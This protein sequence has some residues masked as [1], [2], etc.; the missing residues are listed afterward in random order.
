MGL[1]LASSFVEQ[2]VGT[3]WTVKPGSTI[4]SQSSGFSTWTHQ[5]QLGYYL[6]GLIEGDGSILV[7]EK[8]Q[9]GKVRYPYFK[10]TFHLNNL[11]WANKI[12]EVLGFGT[13]C[14]PKGKNYAVLT[15]YSKEGVLA[16]TNLING[17]MRTPKIEALHRLINMVNQH[18]PNPIPL[19]PLDTTPIGSNAWLAG[20]T[21]SDGNFEVVSMT[22]IRKEITGFKCR[23]KIEQRLEYH[24]DCELFLQAI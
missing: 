19:L 9:S 2:G 18:L 11:P 7:P 24:R 23:F 17:K 5:G 6:A 22:N 15:F 20:F 13:I 1:L 14:Y 3:G 21:D 4:Q 16:I 10:V 12:R 8:V